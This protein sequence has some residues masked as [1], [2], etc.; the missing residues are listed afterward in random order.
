MD[1]HNSTT[2]ELVKYDETARAPERDYEATPSELRASTL[3][4][5]V[6]KEGYLTS[7]SSD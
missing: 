3:A 6:S 1:G 5:Q 4:P 7:G 2:L